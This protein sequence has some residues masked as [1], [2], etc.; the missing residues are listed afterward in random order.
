MD[1]A[2][3]PRRAKWLRRC[4]CGRRIKPPVPPGRAY[5]DQ[6]V[7]PMVRCVRCC[8]LGSEGQERG[9]A[10]HTGSLDYNIERGG[11]GC[12]RHCTP[13]RAMSSFGGKQVVRSGGAFRVR[14]A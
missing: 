9:V 2:A 13:G 4:L 8:Y 3:G 7:K 14:M 12:D 1:T 10:L 6:F 11:Y 5:V